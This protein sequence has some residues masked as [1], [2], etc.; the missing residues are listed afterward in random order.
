MNI[1]YRNGMSFGMRL[2]I[3]GTAFAL[4]LIAGAGVVALIGSSTRTEL[5]LS[6][7][8]QNI[9]VFALPAVLT[10]Y[11]I[12]S[13]PSALLETN[14][15]PSLRWIGF[16]FIIYILVYPALDAVITWNDSWTLPDSMSAFENVLRQT[17]EAAR[18]ATDTML[19]TNSFGGLLINLLIVGVLTG[20][21]EELFFRGAIQRVLMSGGMRP[22]I[23]IWITAFLFSALHFQFY[24]FVPR[25]LMGAYFGWLM[26][27]TGSLWTSA[28]A[29]ALN[30]S[31]VVITTWL[32]NTGYVGSSLSEPGSASANAWIVGASA[33]LTGVLLEWVQ[34]KTAYKH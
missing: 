26:L 1:Q 5:L 32:V 29:H 8:L 3:L 9:I 25:L 13:S 19:A 12:T 33:L 23:A 21:C 22:A 2:M 11:C 14:H 31:I 28:I 7:T 24:G 20:V 4:C 16:I 34:M 27:R 15:A 10:A 17:E 6:A 18:H 30:N